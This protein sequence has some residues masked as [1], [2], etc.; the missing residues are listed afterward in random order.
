M[1][2]DKCFD[3]QTAQLIDAPAAREKPQTKRPRMAIGSA[4]HA[5]QLRKNYAAEQKAL[6]TPRFALRK[7]S[8]H[9]ASAISL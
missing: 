1:I 5:Q 9:G 4:E 3:E 2:Q 7:C 6:P 8:S